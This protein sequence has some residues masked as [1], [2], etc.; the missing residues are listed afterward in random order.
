ML[1]KRIMLRNRSEI[2]VFIKIINSEFLRLYA[3]YDPFE[4]ILLSMLKVNF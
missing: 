1:L 2:Q 3:L 4:F